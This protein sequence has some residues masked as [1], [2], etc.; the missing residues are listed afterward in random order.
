MSRLS[1][2]LAII[3]LLFGTTLSYAGDITPPELV[4]ITISPAT[5]N[6]AVEEKSVTVSLHATD[7]LSGLTPGDGRTSWATIRSPS[8]NQ[9]KNVSFSN[10]TI[11][12]GT[13]TDGVFENDLVFLR[14]SEAGTWVIE[15]VQL[16]D[17]VG[18]ERRYELQE[19]HD[20]G[21]RAELQV[22]EGT[23]HPPVA[24]IGPDRIITNPIHLDGSASSD[25]DGPIA[26]WQWSI[27][28]RGEPVQSWAADG[29]SPSFPHLPPG[30]YDVYLIVTD[31]EGLDD[32][33]IML[34]GVY[35]VIPGD[36]N[37]DGQIG[38]DDA[39]LNLQKVTDIR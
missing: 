35:D 11:V 36:A 33:D 5:I 9:F 25:P 8:G 34:M 23:N 30:F 31:G 20:L 10:S 15:T 32:T 24:N 27:Q 39:I 3:P 26:T 17:S 28:N 7:D 22:L 4:G 29:I 12:S 21:I 6:I 37:Q 13:T 18:N 16:R 14:F 19:L 2:V 1:T 38:I